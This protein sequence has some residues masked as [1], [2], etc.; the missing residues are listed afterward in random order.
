MIRQILLNLKVSSVIPLKTAA[1]IVLLLVQTPSASAALIE[2]VFEF[3]VT[4][5]RAITTPLSDITPP[6]GSVFVDDAATGLFQPNG[7][8]D[9]T[10]FLFEFDDTDVV[11]GLLQ[12]TPSDTI[13]STGGGLFFDA[14]GNPSTLLGNFTIKDDDASDPNGF[15]YISIFE[16]TWDMQP[17][18]GQDLIE[19][20]Y[21][22]STTATPAPATLA[23]LGLGLAG[24]GYQRRRKAV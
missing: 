21:T 23:L 1:I 15:V 5:T 9:V 16:G 10:S 11:T 17:N 18:S 4:G 8:V 22:I 20:T 7:V 12:W 2:F 19:G 6:R 14:L 13:V 3:E 24:I